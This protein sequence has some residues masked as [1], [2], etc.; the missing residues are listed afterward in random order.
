M[1]KYNNPASTPIYRQPC[2][3]LTQTFGMNSLQI[4]NGQQ[5]Q[6][7]LNRMAYEVYETHF[8]EAEVVLAGIS[9]KGYALAQ[10]MHRELSGIGSIH[11]RLVQLN[12]NKRNPLESNPELDVSFDALHQK[13]V[14][15][16][17][18]VI[19]TGQT[20]FYAT[21]PF[22]QVLV[23]QLKVLVLVNRDHTQF[24]FQ[25]DFTGLS[26]ATTVQ[27]HIAVTLTDKD[28]AVYLT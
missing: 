10:M 14:I 1:Q 26:L 3:F 7:R 17:D 18:D 27:E 4:L 21:K 23:K 9:R 28:Q 20:L 16:V 22:H 12:F 6:Y 2:L 15:L 13:T 19:N 5:I 8:D 11:F 24:P 25:P